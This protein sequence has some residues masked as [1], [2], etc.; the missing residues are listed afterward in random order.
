MLLIHRHWLCWY[1][2]RPRATWQLHL[3]RRRGKK[4][5]KRIQ[6]E[7]EFSCFSRALGAEI[8]YLCQTLPIFSAVPPVSSAPNDSLC[9][10]LTTYFFLILMYFIEI[11]LLFNFTT[12]FLE[13]FFSDNQDFLEIFTKFFTISTNHLEHTF[14]TEWK[15]TFFRFREFFTEFFFSAFLIFD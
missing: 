8:P 7:S 6:K 10:N 9:P 5:G 13:F 3:C 1:R 15:I 2:R 12:I 11:F 4:P 14:S